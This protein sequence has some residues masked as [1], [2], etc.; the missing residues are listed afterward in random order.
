MRDTDWPANMIE[1]IGE[2]SFEVKV[3]AREREKIGKG[4]HTANDFITFS[5]N[6]HIKMMVLFNLFSLD[7]GK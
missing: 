6:D 3:M 4:E 5:Q 1:S 2:C 7:V